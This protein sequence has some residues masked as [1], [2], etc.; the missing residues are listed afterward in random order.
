MDTQKFQTTSVSE[1]TPSNS[2]ERKLYPLTGEM[3]AQEEDR[4]LEFLDQYL[5]K[6]YGKDKS[7]D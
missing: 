7:G 6:K 4:M 3:I 5:E 1:N 2:T